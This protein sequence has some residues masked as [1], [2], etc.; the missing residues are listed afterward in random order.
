MTRK[1][2]T[3]AAAAALALG[4]AWLPAGEVAAQTGACRELDPPCVNHAPFITLSPYAGSYESPSAT[5]TMSVHDETGIQPSSFVAKLNGVVVLS[6]GA[7]Y[8]VTYS[9]DIGLS[10]AVGKNTLEVTIC[11]MAGLCAGDAGTY[12]Y[13]VPPPPDSF[14]VAEVGL[15][16]YTE[17][18]RTV[19]PFD[20]SA[21]YAT[22]AYVSL[23]VPRS[24]AMVYNGAQAQARAMVQVDAVDRSVVA[25]TRM[26]IQ[27][28][29]AS[30]AVASPERFYRAGKGTNRLAASWFAPTLP[31]GA[32]T[33]RA[34]VRTY[35]DLPGGTVVKQAAPRAVRVLHLNERRSR[36]GHGWWIAGLQR[37]HFRGDSAMV[38]NGDGTAAFFARS[39]AV[40][41]HGPEGEW[42]ELSRPDSLYQRRWPD[43][44]R[45]VFSPD[46]YL[47]H[48]EDRFGRRTSFHWTAT[49]DGL[50][51]V[52]SR[53]VDPV[54]KEVIFTY[55]YGNALA[56]IVTP[57]GRASAVWYD[58]EKISQIV[59]PDGVT[60]FRATYGSHDRMRT[61]T[62]R[63]GGAYGFAYD[64]AGFVAADTLPS[65]LV[66]GGGMQRPVIRYAGWESALLPPPGTGTPATP[67][68][69][70][71]TLALRAGITD[72]RGMTTK[73]AFD[74]FL[75]PT[76]VE[77]AL[78]DTTLIHRNRH[79]QPTWVGLPTGAYTEYR[80]GDH[81]LDSQPAPSRVVEWE[82]VPEVVPELQ[83]GD[84]EP[85]RV[86]ETSIQYG[87]FNLPQYVTR[88]GLSTV[89]SYGPQGQL[90]SVNSGGYT[91]RYGYRADGRVEWVKDPSGR[92]TDLSYDSTG[93]RNL[94]QVRDTDANG[95]FRNTDFTSDVHG[96]T[97]SV[98]SSAGT[99]QH[100]YDALN[101]DT[102]VVDASG[103]TRF[104]YQGSF[105]WRVTDAAGKAYVFNRNALGWLLS[106]VHPGGLATSYGYDL[107]GNTVR[108]TDRR[109]ASVTFTHDSVGRVW[110][111]TADGATTTYG[112]GEEG[113]WISA[114]NAVSTDTVKFDRRG[115]LVEEKAV[116]A[117]VPNGTFSRV[118]VWHGEGPRRLLTYNTPGGVPGRIEYQYDNAP[119]LSG[120]RTFGQWSRLRYNDAGQPDTIMLR[121]G[122]TAPGPV[123]TFEY[124]GNH[125]PSRARWSVGA[126]D[127]KLGARY[128]WGSRDELL[129]RDDAAATF[130]RRYGYDAVG[131]LTSSAGYL[132]REGEMVCEDPAQLGTCFRPM[133]WVRTDTTDY[134]Y[135]A[136]GN[137]TNAGATLQ[138]NSN[139]YQTFRGYTFEYD[140]EGNLKR[141]HNASYDQTLTWN[142]LG[143]LASVTTNGVTVTYGYNG[144]GQRVKRTTGG[145][146]TFS[147]YDGDDLLMEISGSGA[148][149]REYAHYPGIDQPHS[150]KDAS[151]NVYYYAMELP[152]HVK[153]LFN[154]ANQVV[155]EYAYDPWGEMTAVTENVQQPL[156]YMAR[157]LDPITGLYYVRNRWYDPVANRFVSEDPIGLA[158]GINT[159]AYAGNR[160]TNLRDP[161]GL[162]AGED[163]IDWYLVTYNQRTGDVVAEVHVGQT[164]PNRGF[165]PADRDLSPSERER[166]QCVAEEW[167]SS[168]SR[169]IFLPM[170]NS[171]QVVVGNRPN[172]ANAWTD[173]FHNPTLIVFSRTGR[174]GSTIGAFNEFSLARTIAHETG[175]VSRVNQVGVENY[176]ALLSL[177]QSNTTFPFRYMDEAYARRY[178][179]L[180]SNN[181]TSAARVCPQSTYP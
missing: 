46:G 113:R 11:D 126:L 139:R 168:E 159:Y 63:N 1:L 112:Y 180:H 134:G 106:Q 18:V 160:P 25:P 74:R 67:A 100:R 173:P 181:H 117:G 152:G 149:I 27:V 176:R 137:R 125:M 79:G 122:T 116:L 60:E 13:V 115:R 154:A 93:F 169:G 68:P 59:A 62:D 141:K 9:V 171:G 6:G 103:T 91:T 123:A 24:V 16:S 177:S 4:P 70:V 19:S 178:S 53:I 34:V 161:L 81:A 28:L 174:S 66:E 42:S 17:G 124:W 10:L 131:Q 22:P 23:D 40:T 95:T 61:R 54:G 172:V 108:A 38:T 14:A 89:Y 57:G 36:L 48:V 78:G 119:E 158:G 33:F 102:A 146:S 92:R 52:P 83:F 179:T 150:M 65:V 85:P 76:R 43:G 71:D 29:D 121:T 130:Q 41:F 167:L 12:W 5:V 94:R 58:G 44:T 142:A 30:G 135:D 109:G 156:R 80:Y 153:G 133:Q 26:S 118:S 72:P 165:Q 39:G 55:H 2:P 148:L 32:Y 88:G 49:A 147:V 163:C 21:A 175:H 104:A 15:G 110:T 82:G 162:R 73:L 151:G 90:D 166:L 99:V 20:A 145:S 138:P 96:R 47:K 101:R 128:H 86:V 155:N 8:G 56:T 45:A 120:I 114:S 87:S 98:T 144:F 164:C 97:A 35:W 37:L 170:L 127:A 132:L 105:L 31:T 129:A 75:L 111:R 157:E 7:S 64:S 136:V 51:R 140:A 3:V 50:Y 107:R 143:Q 77:D 69:R 84:P